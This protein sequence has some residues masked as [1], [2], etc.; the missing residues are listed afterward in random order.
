MIALR[1]MLDHQIARCGADFAL[2]VQGQEIL[3]ECAGV[4]LL[5]KQAGSA[6]PAEQ[7]SLLF[8]E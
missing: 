5:V 8:K 1:Q 4:E 3:D 7:P 2:D 6:A